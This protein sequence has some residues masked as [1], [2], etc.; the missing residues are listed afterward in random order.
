MRF[1][2]DL[3]LTSVLWTEQVQRLDIL[4]AA[5]AAGARIVILEAAL[6]LLTRDCGAVAVAEI[7]FLRQAVEYGFVNT[8]Q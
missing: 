1:T 8:E 7:T 5:A 2:Y 3:C 4:E 6:G